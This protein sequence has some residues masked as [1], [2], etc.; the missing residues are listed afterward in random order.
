M[1]TNAE[2]LAVVSV[3]GEVWHPRQRGDSAWRV[4]ADGI[5][6]ALPGTG[7]I[8]YNVRVGMRALGW[9]GDHLEPGVTTRARDDGE[10]AA[11]NL[12]AMVGNTARVVSGDAKG[13]AGYVTGKHGGVEHVLVEFSDEDLEKLLPGDRVLIRARGL[14]LELLDYP[15]VRVTNLDPDLLSVW[16]IREGEGVLYVPV[17]HVVPAKVMGSG[18]GRDN[19]FR[20][21]YDI[22]TFSPDV[23]AEFGL[24]DLRIGDLVAIQDADN[25]FGRIYR[26]G[27]VS[28]G[29][30]VHGGSFIAGHGPGVTT[31]LST[32]APGRVHPIIDPDANL[33]L[34]HARRLAH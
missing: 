11:Y 8:C 19:V 22:Q 12:L 20:G 24:D 29:V 5:P 18:L 4:G 27:A 15:D 7:G 3:V 1:R 9:A 28:V 13:A 14:G 17:T 6:R 23:V 30:V 33:R 16:Q 31:L 2:N 26:A 10:N 32:A 34:L 25:T 21:D